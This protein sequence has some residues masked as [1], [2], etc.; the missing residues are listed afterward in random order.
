MSGSPE[1]CLVADEAGTMERLLRGLDAVDESGLTDWTLIGGLAVMA[2]LS[3]AHRAT[4]DIDTLVR[5]ANPD[6]R[7]V[8]LTVGAEP[9]PT[10]VRLADG[11]KIDAIDVSAVLD[12]DALPAAV[13]PRMFVLS[14]WWMA[15]TAE[16]VRLRLVRR[17]PVETVID[18][19]LRLAR[20]AALVAAKLQSIPT[21]RAR[22]LEKRCS[23]A[24]DVF[25]LLSADP[26][27]QICE[28]LAT[29]PADLGPWCAEYLEE[30]FVSQAVRT[31]GWMSQ[32][33]DRRVEP[34]AVE[35][36][37]SLTAAALRRHLR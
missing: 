27:L 1:V 3:G 22:A 17:S 24:Y 6:A 11:T 34:A 18:R 32:A 36:V 25:R 5:D 14:H 33:S 28:E 23:D 19:S 31:A 15:A 8:L 12:L 30:L 13:E 10:G 29:S 9:T 16:E 37:G 26:A 21:R 20:P 7:A 4:G 35:V 2:R